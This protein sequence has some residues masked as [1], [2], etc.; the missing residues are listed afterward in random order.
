VPD[1][2][3]CGRP[4]TDL[5]HRIPVPPKRDSKAWA[6]LQHQLEAQAIAQASA[7]YERNV[8]RR[9]E[10]ER[11]LAALQALPTSEGRQRSIRDLRRQIESL[12]RH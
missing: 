3:M 12:L 11:Q 8:R 9:H 5:G 7:M 4:C 2:A 6:E 10:L 1:C